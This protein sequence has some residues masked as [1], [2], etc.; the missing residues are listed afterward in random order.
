MLKTLLP[1]LV[2][3]LLLASCASAPIVCPAPP[4]QLV[5]EPLGLSFQDEM[6]R[7]LQGL[8]PEQ[9]PSAQPL[10]SA[11]AGPTK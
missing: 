11:T 8:L 2:S 5:K 6:Q 10:P 3:L 9:T 4:P 1:M 7:L